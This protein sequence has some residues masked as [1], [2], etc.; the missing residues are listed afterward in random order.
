M[1]LWLQIS[2]FAI[3]RIKEVN[4]YVCFKH[5]CVIICWVRILQRV[6]YELIESGY[7]TPEPGYERSMGTKRLVNKDS[8]LQTFTRHSPTD[9]VCI[10]CLRWTQPCAWKQNIFHSL[11][12]SSWMIAHLHR[13]KRVL[14]QT[15]IQTSLAISP[16]IFLN[17]LVPSPS[18][19]N[20]LHGEKHW[21]ESGSFMK[22][23]TGIS[24]Q[25][26]A[27]TFKTHSPI[28]LREQL[29]FSLVCWQI[30]CCSLDE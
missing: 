11:F 8:R 18:F 21:N 5:F 20:S 27:L 29:Q 4:V 30:L 28:E 19:K 2:F 1:I 3:T 25:A 6:G 12:V 17:T 23:G 14:L 13:Q 7:E 26:K 22:P 24:A 10:T 16:A 9:F 15:E